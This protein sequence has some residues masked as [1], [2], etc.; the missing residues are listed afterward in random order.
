MTRSFVSWCV[1]MCGPAVFVE[2][3]MLHSLFLGNLMIVKIMASNLTR[4]NNFKHI[5]AAITVNID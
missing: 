5:I 1:S 2:S 3:V 4:E